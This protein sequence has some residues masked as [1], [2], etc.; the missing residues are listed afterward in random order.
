M[1]IKK[2]KQLIFGLLVLVLLVPIFVHAATEISNGVLIRA[3]GT[4]GVYL[5]EGEYKRSIKS[6]E[7]FLSR[8]YKWN[9]VLDVEP[10]ILNNY[11]TASDVTISENLDIEKETGLNIKINVSKLRVRSLPSLK[12]EIT[13]LV[14]EGQNFSVLDEQ[15]DW[16]KIKYEIKSG[17]IKTGWVMGK[18]TVKNENQN[19]TIKESPV[20]KE[21]TLVK[22]STHPGVYLIE[23][24]KQ[25]P[26]KSAEIFE[27]NGYK[28]GNVKVIS[29]AEMDS[30]PIGS[31]VTIP[32]EEIKKETPKRENGIL[33]K[34]SNCLG[35]YLIENGKKR[36]IKSAEIF[37][38]KGYKWGD[39]IEISQKEMDS[40]PL[41][42]AVTIECPAGT[43]LCNN[44][45]WP[46]CL[47]NQEFY[48][49]PKGEA[50]CRLCS[51]C[52]YVSEGT[53]VKYCQ[54]TDTSCGCTS[55][56]NCNNSDRWVNVGSS[57]SCCDGDKTCTC[58]KQDY[59]DYSCSG[60]SCSYLLTNTQIN[61]SG[62][63]DCA[64]SEICSKGVCKEKFETQ[65]YSAMTIG[66]YV[67]QLGYN[68]S[69]N[70]PQAITVTKVEFFDENG[71]IQHT[72]SQ[73]TLQEASHK[74]QLLPGRTFN[75]SLSF[76]I[77]HSTEEIE[78]WQIKWCCLDSDGDMFVVSNQ[79]Y[80]NPSIHIRDCEG[81]DTSCGI[82]F[83][84]NCNNQDGCV[85]KDYYDY[86]CNGTSCE[87]NITQNS[88][89]CAG[90]VIKGNIGYTTQ[91]KIY[92]LP[93]C[94]SY[95]DTKIAEGY[96]E[97]WFCTEQEARDAGWR[98]AYNCP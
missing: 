64:L 6:A 86:Y 47:T 89:D 68:L 91:E 96:G 93:E 78:K 43:I 14:S 16:Y 25:R 34:L 73:S 51:T 8:G 74:G 61:K 31:D 55:C 30:Y 69:N 82:N 1:T 23:D 18:Y 70:S 75:W 67:Y 77:P 11:P 3:K 56:V 72:I 26:I 52:S 65:L 42:S 97:R 94:P 98:K 80:S 38:A 33:V 19:K 49:P 79:G 15:N 5:I 9:D 41:G 4:P 32:E 90:C 58:Q 76:Q 37:L 24:G 35:I 29:R 85:G 57:Y 10:S 44:Q 60:I 22:L 87:A 59:H 21:K 63:I 66:S 40:Y 83:C 20:S 27:A 88:E 54:G 13:A 81:T 7:I 46:P 45:C 48:C 36:P 53:C 62:C 92:H 17:T 2:A 12:G 95:N 84:T 50:Q 28:W 71:N 39:V